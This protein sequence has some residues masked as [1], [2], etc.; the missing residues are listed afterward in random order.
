MAALAGLL[1]IAAGARA[2]E[3]VDLELVLAADGSGSIDADE[4]RLQRQGY[5]EAITSEAV[6][7]AIRG[8]RQGV[9]ALAFVEWAGP[10]SV[11]TIVDW[12]VIRGANDARAF[13]TRLTS[14]PRVALGYNSIS[15]AIAH[16]TRLIEGNDYQ[17]AR[18]V[19]DV[20]GDGPQ[21]G[22]RPLALMRA[23]ALSAGITINA[24]LIRRDGG[25]RP[26]P[27][28]MPLGEHYARDVIGGFG[29]FVMTVE[30]EGEFAQ[31]VR[32][33]M[34]LEIAGAEPESPENGAVIRQADAA[35]R[36][37]D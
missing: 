34:V 35:S 37:D 8:G 36:P 6:L 10:E 26:G 9:I 29:A 30:S 11:H 16:S 14:A 3:P 20:S 27:G 31:A 12:M 33:K 17:G 24:L 18:K 5:A 7:A 25:G 23:Q 28:G 19:I 1:L 13:A 4:F 22:G 32:R 2:A 15:E 21:I